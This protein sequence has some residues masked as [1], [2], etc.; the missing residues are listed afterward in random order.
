M[1]RFDSSPFDRARTLSIREKRRYP[2]LQWSPLRVMNPWHKL[3]FLIAQF[4]LLR[5][6]SFV[7]GLVL[8]LAAAALLMEV[9]LVAVIVSLARSFRG[10][11]EPVAPRRAW[12]RLTARPLAGWWLGA[13]Y[14][15]SALLPALS[16][17][18]PLPA[19]QLAQQ[20]IVALLGLAFLNSSIRLT[21][22]RRYP[23]A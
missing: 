22:L 6:L 3:A 18:R 23:Q 10:M 12:W 7:V 9:V 11:G 1:A 16:V 8:P 15:I 20:A 14:L 5:A 2:P 19:W 4:L 21:L 13:L 17:H